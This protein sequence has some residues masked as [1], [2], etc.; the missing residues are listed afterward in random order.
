MYKE[1]D[2]QDKA[3]SKICMGP[4]WDFDSGFSYAASGENIYFEKSDY[5]ISLHPFFKRFFD[6]PVFKARY[7][8]IW[9]ANYT[10]IRD[11]TSFIDTTA[12]KLDKSQTANFTVWQWLNKTNY[13]NEISKLKRWWTDRA[14]YLH[15]ESS[16]RAIRRRKAR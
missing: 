6:D 14:E 3:P 2:K 7:K 11:I 13:L 4:L 12:V 15:A 10:K 8:E 1:K 5:R 16:G 9:N